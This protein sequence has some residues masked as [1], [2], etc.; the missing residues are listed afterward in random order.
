MVHLI[1]QWWFFYIWCR[2]VVWGYLKRQSTLCFDSTNAGCVE[3]P[4][5]KQ[6]KNYNDVKKW[7]DSWA[8]QF[9]WVEFEIDAGILVFVKCIVC[10]IMTCQ[11]IHIMLKC[12][13]LDKHM[14]RQQTNHDIL[15]RGWRKMRFITTRTTNM[16][17][18]LPCSMLDDQC[19]FCKKLVMLMLRRIGVKLTNSPL[20]S[21]FYITFDP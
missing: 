17:E 4:T 5:K 3:P 1:H 12:D 20:S 7:Q 16:L 8:A 9:A 6:N 2:Q 18:I 21:M 15:A 10:E 11:I 14:G 19:L 13:N